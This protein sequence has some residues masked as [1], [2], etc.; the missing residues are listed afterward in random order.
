MVLCTNGDH[1]LYPPAPCWLTSFQD[2]VVNGRLESERPNSQKQVL[3]NN[4]T[5]HNSNISIA[6]IKLKMCT[7]IYN[8][9]EKSGI[10]ISKYFI[11]LCAFVAY[12]LHV[13]TISGVYKFYF[14]NGY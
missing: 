9:T 8:P 6:W 5:M 1:I 7:F 11:F 14:Q 4:R 10:Y 13:K 12:S 2:L 3:D